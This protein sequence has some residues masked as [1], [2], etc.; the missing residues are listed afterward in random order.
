MCQI[1]KNLQ[2][3][4]IKN[5]ILPKTCILFQNI[6][7]FPN[8]LLPMVTILDNSKA[9]EVLA[10]FKI[11]TI[12]GADVLACYKIRTCSYLGCNIFN[13]TYFFITTHTSLFI[14]SATSY[15]LRLPH[16]AERRNG[17]YLEPV[18]ANLGTIELIRK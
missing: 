11:S 8:F 18:V 3:D 17:K 5:I 10:H 15:P 2:N 9:I 1:L 14:L 13:E 12:I 4:E 6:R 7:N 16:S